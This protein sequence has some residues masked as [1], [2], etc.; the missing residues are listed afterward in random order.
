MNQPKISII[1]PVHNAGIYF[2]KCL[3]TLVTQTLR[4]LE[5]ILVL[6]CPTDG[7]DKVAEAFAAKDDRIKL[8]YNEEN[9]HTGLS[10]NKGVKAAKGKYIGFHDHDD[11]SEPT[12]YELLYQKAEQEN[13]DVVRCNFSCIYNKGKEQIIEEYK[14]PDISIDLSNKK[15]IYESVCNDTIS[16]VIWN[17]IYRA[18]FL[19]RNHIQFL[20]S[21]TICSEDSIFFLNVYRHIDR[22]GIVPEYLYYHVFHSNNTGKVYNYRSIENRIAFFNGLYLFLKK[23]NINERQSKDFVSKNIITSLY[24]GS[25]QALL[26]L[27]R[28]K[29]IKE[30][31]YIRQ[32]ELMMN[33]IKSLYKRE[34]SSVLLSQKPTV[35]IFSFILNLLGKKT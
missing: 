4:E 10:R 18:D 32:N 8:I 19:D 17:H 26:S 34:N 1:V 33:C 35:I 28:K 2:D 15:K 20:D 30:I 27:P 6:D 12:M 16:C 7:S 23:N 5:I 31:Q 22:I 14:Y 9:L 29:A 3:T 13:L 11:Y 24:S 21:R 25:R